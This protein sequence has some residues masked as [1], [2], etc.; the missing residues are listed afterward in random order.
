METNKTITEDYVHLETAKLLAEKGFNEDTMCV[1]IG[2]YL[3]IKGDSTI[4]NRTDMPI[5]PA[6]TLQ[7][8]MKW[9]REV[10]HIFIQVELYSKRN[11]YCFEVFKNT[12]R[13]IIKYLEVCSSYEEAVEAALNYCLINLI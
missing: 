1:Y 11:D 10:H 6:P 9:L 3:L 8:A 7:M 13:M 4:Y 5:I 12:H 2:R